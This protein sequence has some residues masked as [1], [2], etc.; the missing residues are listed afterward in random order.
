MFALCGRGTRSSLR[1]LRHGLKISDLAK[2]PLPGVPSAVWTIRENF[3]DLSDRFII[4]SFEDTTLVLALE[5]DHV[6]EVQDSNF[7]RDT[8]TFCVGQLADGS[9]IQVHPGG[10]RRI[11]R[12]LKDK[13]DWAAPAGS[14]VTHGNANERQVILVLNSGEIVYFELS[15]GSGG[16]LEETVHKMGA[17]VR[18]SCVDIGEV[19]QGALR[20]PYLALG[21]ESRRVE[22]LS[23]SPGPNRFSKL[24]IQSFEHKPSSVNLSL[25]KTENGPARTF[26]TIGVHR[27]YL[28][29]IEVSATGQL[30]GDTARIRYLGSSPVKLFKVEV[31]GQS[32]VLALSSRPW[33]LYNHQSQFFM[34]PFSSGPLDFAAN[35]RSEHVSEGIVAIA[36]QELRII[37]VHQLGE[38]FH[39]ESLPLSHTPRKAINDSVTGKLFV[40]ETDHNAFTDQQKAALKGNLAAAGGGAKSDAEEVDEAQCGAPMPS[41]PGIWASCVRV[42]DCN[43]LTTQ[44]KIELPQ[45]EAAFSLCFIQV[46]RGPELKRYLVVGTAKNLE[47]HPRKVECG[48]IR[49]YEINADGSLTDGQHKKQVDDVPYALCPFHGQLLASCGKTLNLYAFGKKTLLLKCAN[50]NFPFFIASL[51]TLNRRIYVGDLQD[52]VV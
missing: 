52:S 10:Y 49:W 47:L 42:V 34:T 13:T 30:N 17:N 40:I 27:G 37:V 7:L 4:M 9:V 41:R 24:G 16:E 28:I 35:F 18:I 15:E 8:K 25:S 22:L 21:Y 36:G 44:Q 5:D 31:G 23:L 6:R 46:P 20:A 39:Q 3:E 29:R 50:G 2:S 33:L 12:G 48:Y 38:V 11:A 14:Q 51:H 1:M 32:A 26:L 43:S 19:P 45:N